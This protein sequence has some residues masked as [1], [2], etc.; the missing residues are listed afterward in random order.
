MALYSESLSQEN[1]KNLTNMHRF[2]KIKYINSTKD[3]DVIFN[4]Y[5]KDNEQVSKI[6]K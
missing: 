5:S 3:Q 6:Y 4:Q 2:K 1:K